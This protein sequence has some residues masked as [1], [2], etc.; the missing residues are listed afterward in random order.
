MAGTHRGRSRSGLYFVAITVQEKCA[1]V[2]QACAGVSL[3]SNK[4]EREQGANRSIRT[5]AVYYRYQWPVTVLPFF[6][7]FPIEASSNVHAMP[8]VEGRARWSLTAMQQ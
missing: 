6:S 7:V 3:R 4:Q 8:D 1:A 2:V 5:V